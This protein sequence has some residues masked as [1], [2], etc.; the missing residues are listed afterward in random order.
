MLAVMSDSREVLLCGVPHEWL[1]NTHDGRLCSAVANADRVVL[2]H[3]HPVEFLLLTYFNRFDPVLNNNPD[4][5]WEMSNVNDRA[6]R[7]VLELYSDEKGE[8]AIETYFAQM[9]AEVIGGFAWE[10]GSA[11]A[12]YA[13]LFTWSSLRKKKLTVSVTGD[14]VLIL[15]EKNKDI[16]DTIISR[17]NKG[18]DKARK[19][20]KILEKFSERAI[21]LHPSWK[22]YF[23]DITLLP[24]YSNRREADT[25]MPLSTPINGARACY[26]LP[27][28]R[29]ADMHS[30]RFTM[31]EGT[32]VVTTKSSYMTK[33]GRKHIEKII[34]IESRYP[35]KCQEDIIQRDVAE[36]K[37]YIDSVCSVASK[38]EVIKQ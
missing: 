9:V 21:L 32:D 2:I 35:K 34:R 4:V 24:E 23:A 28:P 17:M 37:D 5:L 8:E 10:D 1:L 12:L 18:V 3:P 38:N 29:R 15:T 13:L 27:L 16:Y 36:A 20:H 14:R 31:V 26:H 11:L 30:Y 33:E 25:L 19:F 22:L 7:K 6:R